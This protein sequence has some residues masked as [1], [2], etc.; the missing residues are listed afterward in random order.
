MAPTD[1]IMQVVEPGHVQ[2]SSGEH[3]RGSEHNQPA[4]HAMNC[5]SGSQ[6]VGHIAVLQCQVELHQLSQVIHADLK[7]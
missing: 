7:L 6:G 1:E 5:W 3:K 4:Q 2:T